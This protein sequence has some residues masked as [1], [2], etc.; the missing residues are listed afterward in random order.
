M[1]LA[2][3]VALRTNELLK[4]ENMEIQSLMEA[5]DVLS[6]EMQ[7]NTRGGGGLNL[8]IK[9]KVVVKPRDDE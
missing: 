6:E 5:N 7:N 8:C 1:N 9:G 3:A 4:N 2:Q